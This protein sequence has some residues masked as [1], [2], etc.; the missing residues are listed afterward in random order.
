MSWQTASHKCR[1]DGGHLA[2]VHSDEQR[3]CLNRARS[4]FKTSVEEGQ[5]VWVGLHF[6]S[7][8]R[9]YFWQTGEE[10]KTD[11]V[12]WNQAPELNPEADFTC[13]FARLGEPT[14][15]LDHGDC[16][17]SDDGDAAKGF[18]CEKLRHGK[19][20]KPNVSHFGILKKAISKRHVGQHDRTHQTGSEGLLSQSARKDAQLHNAL[21]Q[22]LKK[23][24]NRHRQRRS[25]GKRSAETEAE[26][27][28]LSP[29]AMKKRSAE[30][31]D[32][33][34]NQVRTCLCLCVRVCLSVFL[35]ARCLCVCVRVR[36]CVCVC[37]RA[38]AIV[39]AHVC[40]LL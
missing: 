33:E 26:L 31:I 29:I 25:L 2:T 16:G 15:Y 1:F 12:G 37:A 3:L 39:H 8:R 11:A 20:L 24:L 13:G 18:V 32:A 6:D 35:C 17:T 27:S 9:G 38:R 21:L 28:E 19:N 36:V 5:E 22:G 30:G 23:E 34:G 14:S 40:V 7:S 10:E 4:V